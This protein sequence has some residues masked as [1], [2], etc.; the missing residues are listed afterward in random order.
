MTQS[1][2]TLYLVRHGQTTWNLERRL[3][4]HLDSRLTETG[5]NQA[6]AAGELL[7]HTSITAAFASPLGR[8]M[9]TAHLII[10]QRNIPLTP[11]EGL[12]E[13]GLGLLEGMS[14]DEAKRAH[15]IPF[16]NFWNQPHR[17]TLEGAETVSQLQ[18]RVLRSITDIA[19]NHAGQ[20][21]LLVSHAIAIKTAL[22]FFLKKELT[23]L[24]EIILPENGSILTI[25]K[26]R[27]A[28]ALLNPD[29]CIQVGPQPAPLTC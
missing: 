6:M 27:G 29:A 5:R 3:Q 17:F 7:S 21:L 26:T 23:E 24:G 2:T 4:G 15:P 18:K 20:S 9:E 1:P 28:F 10:G 25:Q 14:M 12:K 11:K 8:A 22:A 19:N 13:I 16:A